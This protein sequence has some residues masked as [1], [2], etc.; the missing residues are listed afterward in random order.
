MKGKGC[1]ILGYIAV[2]SGYCLGVAT[3]I[4]EMLGGQTATDILVQIKGFFPC[5][6]PQGALPTLG[7]TLLT[8]AAGLSAVGVAVCLPLGAF[9]TYGCGVFTAATFSAFGIKGILPF[10][11]TLP[12]TVTAFI[13]MAAV[14]GDGIRAS[15]FTLQRLGIITEPKSQYLPINDFSI[16]RY[17]KST[18]FALLIAGGVTIYG[19]FVSGYVF[20]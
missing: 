4:R 2:I 11:L 9:A 5:L 12:I 17:I 13:L 3:A 7:L 19:H 8:A 14:S 10:L 1:L 16:P 6:T 15:F 20:H 18:L